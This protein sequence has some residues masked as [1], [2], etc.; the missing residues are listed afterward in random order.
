MTLLN[1]ID[2]DCNLVDC[3]IDINP[4][5]QGGFIAGTGHEI[6]GIDNIPARGLDSAVVMNPNYMNEIAG[7]LEKQNTDIKLLTW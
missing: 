3:V 5:K 2:P 6:I 4:N 1:L 7:T